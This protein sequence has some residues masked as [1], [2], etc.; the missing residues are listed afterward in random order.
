ML[1][2][3]I[4]PYLEQIRRREMTN[5]QLAALVGASEGHIC[6]LLK[7]LGVTREPPP[8]R[9]KQSAL[10][11]ARQAHRLHCALTMSIAKAAKAC[12]CSER[13]IYR[14]LKKYVAEKSQPQPD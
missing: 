7:R 11:K 6:R 14:I 3:K 5:R 8:D 4:A 1:A 2:T 13:T 12:Y 10:Y 9:K